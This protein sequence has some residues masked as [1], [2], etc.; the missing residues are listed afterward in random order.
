MRGRRGTAR[1][2]W[3]D[4]RHGYER[5]HASTTH[6]WA[7]RKQMRAQA[8]SGRVRAEVLVPFWFPFVVF[9][10]EV[11]QYYI[12]MKFLVL[13]SFRVDSIP[14]KSFCEQAMESFVVR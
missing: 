8:G 12:L 2:R 1:A 4:Q 5:S 3:C 11:F 9:S 7:A 10:N 14:M 13:I 6:E